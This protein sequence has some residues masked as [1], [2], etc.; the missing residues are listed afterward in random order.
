M[1][2]DALGHIRCNNSLNKQRGRRHS[3]MSDT[4]RADVVQKQHTRLVTGQKLHL[5][6]V[7]HCDSDTVAVGVGGKH[8]IGIQT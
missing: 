1:G 8:Q 6:T 3:T 5:R 2:C 4:L 7:A